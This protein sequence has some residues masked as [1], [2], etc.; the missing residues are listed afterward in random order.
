MYLYLNISGMHSRTVY[1]FIKSFT[2]SSQSH[3]VCV[4]VS[5]LRDLCGC[6]EK[7]V[8]SVKYILRITGKEVTHFSSAII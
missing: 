6:H 5:D 2:Q 3:C 7:P 4:Y 8:D 1:F